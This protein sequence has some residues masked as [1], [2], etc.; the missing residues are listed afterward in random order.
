MAVLLVLRTKL[1]GTGLVMG[2]AA[3]AKTSGLLLI[4]G[5]AI[6]RCYLLA[7]LISPY[8]HQNAP[9]LRR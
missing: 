5:S 6:A 1:L 3:M 8:D 7:L 2:N 4:R 9:S